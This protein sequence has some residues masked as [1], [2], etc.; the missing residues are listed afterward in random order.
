[1]VLLALSYGAT[2]SD[3][4]VLP[5]GIGHTTLGASKSRFTVFPVPVIHLI[6]GLMA[7][8]MLSPASVFGNIQRRISYSNMFSTCLFTIAL[9]SDFEGLEFFGRPRHQHSCPMQGGLL[10]AR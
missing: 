7:A 6:H 4:P 10:L 2:P 9:K 8:I 1:M 3:L 5:A